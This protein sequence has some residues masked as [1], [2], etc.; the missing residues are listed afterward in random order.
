MPSED[1]DRDMQEERVKDKLQIAELQH[2]IKLLQEQLANQSHPLAD[3]VD[4]PPTLRTVPLSSDMEASLE[5]RT[6]VRIR[7][8]C[9]PNRAGNSLCAWHDVR[10]ERRAFPPR[11]APS[12]ILNCGC[13]VEEAMFE[14]SLARHGVGS[15]HPGDSVRLDPVLRNA[16]LKLMES[17]YGYRDG[18]FEIDP[19]NGRWIEGEG[20][21]KW[22]AAL[23]HPG[24][25]LAPQK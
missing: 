20:H 25:G 3:K 18:D 24:P 12:G 7:K 14:E 23:L 1:S 19:R 2:Q 17:R 6:Q 9:A 22:E 21:E 8:I 13:T 4:N 11:M 16:L 5:K 10:R 15:F